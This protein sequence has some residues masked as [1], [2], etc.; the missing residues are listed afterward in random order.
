MIQWGEE[1]RKANPGHFCEAVCQQSPRKPV[2]LVTDARRPSDISYFT[3]RYC[4][5]TV[6]VT[7]G[8]GVRRERGWSF[9]A[10]VDDAPSECAL[11]DYKCDVI[12]TNEGAHSSV[13]GQLRNLKQLVNDKL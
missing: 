1:K 9:V 3:A 6:R 7:A 5:L 12:I 11:D 10:G 8:E 2:W 13:M 4:C